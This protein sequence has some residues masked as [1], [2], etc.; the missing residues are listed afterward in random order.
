M[1]KQR[2]AIGTG[3]IA[4]LVGLVWLDARLSELRPEPIDLSPAA[5]DWR[6]LVFDGGLITL[7]AAALV[8]GVVV[9]LA[10]MVRAAGANPVTWWAALVGVLLTIHPHVAWHVV[11]ADP[12]EVALLLLAAGLVGSVL[13]VMA[14][15]RTAG[16]LMD[17]ASTWFIATYCGYLASFA[18]RMRQEMPGGAGAWAVLYFIAVVKFA[19]IFAYGT[20]LLFGRRKLAG[21]LSPGKTVEGFIGGLIGAM[22]TAVLLWW[23]G[24]II[25]GVQQVVSGSW[26]HAA[27]I[28]LVL[29]GVGQ[30]GDLMESL[31]KRGAEQKDS[32][33]LLPGFGGLFD[34]LDSPLVAAPVAWL[35]LT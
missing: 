33:R 32:G 23:L 3:L 26:L 20:G 31:L 16:A 17:V 7:V 1:V 27:A 9:E 24:G 8:L 18:V 34:L 30:V 35:L 29:G 5:I 19:D 22:L 14:R 6:G 11:G 2:V 4:L 10:R 25:E 28:G 15:K 21:W 12:Q 13:A